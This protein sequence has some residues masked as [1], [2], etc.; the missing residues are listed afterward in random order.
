MVETASDIS[1]VINAFVNSGG[2]VQ[3]QSSLVSGYDFLYD[4][5]V[6]IQSVNLSGVVVRHE[7]PAQA[8]A[9]PVRLE[10]RRVE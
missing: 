7:Q 1:T 9:E 8:E 5:A 3:P 10:R 6:E 2:V 4:A